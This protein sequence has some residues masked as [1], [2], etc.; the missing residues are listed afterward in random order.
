MQ[1]AP[2]KVLDLNTWNYFN[3]SQLG[4]TIFNYWREWLH[5]ADTKTHNSEFPPPGTK[6]LRVAH[7]E[8]GGTGQWDLQ[9][10]NLFNTRVILSCKRTRNMID[11]ANLW[12]KSVLETQEDLV[13]DD[14]NH[15]A[16]RYAATKCPLLADVN[17]MVVGPRLKRAR[18]AESSY[19]EEGI[20]EHVAHRGSSPT[21]MIHP[22][23]FSPPLDHRHPQA[24]SPYQ[25]H[26]YPA[27]TS[28]SASPATTHPACDHAR[29]AYASGSSQCSTTAYNRENPRGP[30]MVTL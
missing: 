17:T 27:I 2:L 21:V 23:Y 5:R 20:I 29:V 6:D 14:L 4:D 25:H 30:A 9:E 26:Q 13:L 19:M 1:V 28:T 15:T 7:W 10:T 8:A 3:A 12:K 18:E 22:N 11:L 24:P 16:A